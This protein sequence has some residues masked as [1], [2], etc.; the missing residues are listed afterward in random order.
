MNINPINIIIVIIVIL[1]VVY[2]INK[3]I[4]I[5]HFT[6]DEAVQNIASLYNQSKFAVTDLT[7][8]GTS[9][10][11]TVNVTGNTQFKGGSWFPY[12]DGNNYITSTN[13]ILRGGPTSVQGDLNVTGNS[14]LPNINTS[15][16]INVNTLTVGAGG[17]TINGNLT[18]NGKITANGGIK[19]GPW[20]FVSQSDQL[21]IFHNTKKG[22]MILNSTGGMTMQAKAGTG[23]G[24]MYGFVDFLTDCPGCWANVL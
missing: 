23:P 8:T 5:E 2:I 24:G 11:N 1:I 13:N 3:C 10:L 9:N 21:Y 20:N 4:N 6:N 22:G 14:N 7:A 19:L 17:A 15:G 16:N 12:T 18:V